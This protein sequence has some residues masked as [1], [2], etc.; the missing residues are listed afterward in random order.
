MKIE[1]S[2]YNQ[3]YWI[4]NDKKKLATINS[5]PGFAPFNEQLIKK[6]GV[7]Y[8]IWNPYKSKW[9]A[10]II[11]KIKEFP[12]KEDSKI[13]YLGAASGQSASYLADIAKKGRIFCVEISQ[14]VARDLTFVAEKKEN[15]FPILADAKKPEEYDYIG[16]VDLIFQ[17]VAVK[18]QIEV[19]FK[20]KNFLKKNG[21]V[22]LAIKSRSIDV[23]T[24]PNKIFKEVEGKIR[25]KF[26]IIDKKILNPFE[27]DH[28]LFLLRNI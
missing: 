21:Y 17:D 2:K 20:N 5:V 13:L 24:N 22:L 26:D 25:E 10:G 23:S 12:V 1:K 6:D 11:K 14:R 9:A 15:M 19:L 3:I 7:E 4:K 18:N 8:R 28:M 16:K 27:K